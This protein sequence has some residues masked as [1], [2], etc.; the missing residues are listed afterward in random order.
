LNSS[1]CLTGFT[2]SWGKCRNP[3]CSKNS[4]CICQ[5]PTPSPT[6]ATTAKLKICKL[7]DVNG[8]GQIDSED[9]SMSWNFIYK[10]QD[11]EHNVGTGWFTIFNKGCRE[12]TV[13]VNQWVNVKEQGKSGWI[14]TGLYQDNN[15]VGTN[16]YNYVATIGSEKTVIFLNHLEKTYTPSPN[17]SGEPNSCNGT[18]GSNY[19][20][21]GGFFCHDG[22]C[23]NPNC[24]DDTSCG[25][26]ALPTSSPLPPAVVLGATAPPVLPK[27]GADP[28][29]LATGFVGLIGTGFWFFKKFKLI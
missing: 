22:F 1:Q 5:S 16:D 11:E 6:P 9:K 4:N 7:N 15:W 27:T 12:V 21:Q 14:E 17:P 10:Y 19:N 24:S 18:C 8:N 2:C 23:R 29:A 13:P 25:C 26:G 3:S 28:F 20:C